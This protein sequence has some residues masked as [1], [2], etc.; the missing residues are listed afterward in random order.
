LVGLAFCLIGVLFT[1]P[2]AM[3]AIQ[4][5]IGEAYRATKETM[6]TGIDTDFEPDV[7]SIADA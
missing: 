4:Y 5:L 3:M 2:Y 7:K 1:A 6:D